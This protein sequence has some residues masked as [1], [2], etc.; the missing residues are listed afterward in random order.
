MPVDFWVSSKE[1]ITRCAKYGGCGSCVLLVLN[2]H[3]AWMEF[4]TLQYLEKWVSIVFERANHMVLFCISHA[5]VLHR[6]ARR[7]EL[8]WGYY[9]RCMYYQHFWNFRNVW[10]FE[11]LLQLHQNI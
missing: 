4:T 8:P 10:L 1:V 11:L 5:V 7:Q 9:L 3:N 2:Q 6:E